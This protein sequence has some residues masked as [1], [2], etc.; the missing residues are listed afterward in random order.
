MKISKREKV[1][2]VILIIVAIFIFWPT[3]ENTNIITKN[4]KLTPKFKRVIERY[5]KIHSL[6][7]VNKE[8]IKNKEINI[9]RNIFKYSSPPLKEKTAEEIKQEQELINQQKKLNQNEIIQQEQVE[10]GPV[11]PDVDFKVEGIIRTKLGNA[12]VISKQPELFVIK[13]KTKFFDKFIFKEVKKDSVV[14]GFIGFENEKII[15][16][17]DRGF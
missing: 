10:T 5:K 8:K 15:P 14:L 3:S 11:L 12:I 9:N 13:E 4:A 2:S 6:K 1:L 17:E 7:F 16:I